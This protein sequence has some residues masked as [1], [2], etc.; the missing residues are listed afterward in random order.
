ME[1]DDQTT[2]DEQIL[3]TI[4]TERGYLVGCTDYN[5]V[6]GQEIRFLWDLDNLPLHVNQSF[7]V[8][9]QTDETDFA[10]QSALIEH[11]W[12]DMNCEGD[13]CDGEKFYRIGTD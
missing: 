2:P 9:R 10:M 8:I 11:H 12:P 3:Q 7:R 6:V 5:L 13:R 1:S 4:I